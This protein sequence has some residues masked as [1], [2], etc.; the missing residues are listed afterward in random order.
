MTTFFLLMALYPD[1]QKRAREEIDRIVGDNMVPHKNKNVYALRQRDDY[2]N[3]SLG[4]R[5]APG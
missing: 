2:R 3:H 5:C 4:S 1:V